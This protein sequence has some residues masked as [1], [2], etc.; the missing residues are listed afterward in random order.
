MIWAMTVWIVSLTLGG[1][2]LTTKDTA[3]FETLRDCLEAREEA[4]AVARGVERAEGTGIFI[5]RCKV[6]DSA[7]PPSPTWTEGSRVVC[8]DPSSGCRC[9]LD[10]DPALEEGLR[11]IAE[12]TQ[13]EMARLGSRGMPLWQRLQAL[14][15][16]GH[17]QE[18]RIEALEAEMARFRDAWQLEQ[19]YWRYLAHAG[20][21][22]RVEHVRP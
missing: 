10:D 8:P 6:V 19:A 7:R 17:R 14:A 5:G 2:T 4:W 21:T 18:R 9:V 22:R 20:V 16:C 3:T 11:M 15:G 12:R 1:G 13:C